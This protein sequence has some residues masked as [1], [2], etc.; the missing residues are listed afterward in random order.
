MSCYKLILLF[1]IK[2]IL[3]RTDKGFKENSRNMEILTINLKKELINGN[4]DC[5]KKWD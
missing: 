3:W 1:K 5:T 4:S 2:E